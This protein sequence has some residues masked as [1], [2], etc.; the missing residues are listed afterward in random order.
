MWAEAQQLQGFSRHKVSRLSQTIYSNSS[1]AFAAIPRPMVCL[2]KT[3]VMQT[4]QYS[5][6]TYNPNNKYS[7]NDFYVQCK[8]LHSGRPMDNP[9][10]NSF[11][12]I[13]RSQGQRTLLFHLADILYLSKQLR[14]QLLGSVI[15]FIRIRD[16]AVILHELSLAATYNMDYYAKTVQQLQDLKYLNQCL[17]LKLQR[18][19]ELK[20]SLVN[21]FIQTSKFR[22]V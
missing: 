4:N 17:E 11:V 16:Y 18:T 3:S 21:L 9:I 20:D 22:I 15:P 10:P 7:A 1:L 19:N 2:T 14:S 5:I 13:C 12:V 6:Q 8:G